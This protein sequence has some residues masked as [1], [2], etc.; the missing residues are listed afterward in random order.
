LVGEG[1]GAREAAVRALEC[2]VRIVPVLLLNLALPRNCQAVA[3][4]RDFEVR[5]LD[6][7]QIRLE[8]VGVLGLFDLESRRV[9]CDRGRHQRYELAK[10]I[11]TQHLAHQP[12]GLQIATQSQRLS[13]ISFR[14]SEIGHDCSSFALRMP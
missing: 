12:Q 5:F 4:N 6:T 9:P 10:R 8:H 7:G 2:V 14:H 3:G 13:T 11:Q 1:K